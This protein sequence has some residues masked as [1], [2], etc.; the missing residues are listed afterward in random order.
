MQ[1]AFF[2]IDIA[3]VEFQVMARLR[4]SFQYIVCDDF[5]IYR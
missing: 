5:P 4:Y 2:L 3:L 1:W